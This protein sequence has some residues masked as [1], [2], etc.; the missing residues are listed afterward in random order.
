[1][2]VNGLFPLND[3][4]NILVH[5]VFRC[6]KPKLTNTKLAWNLLMSSLK[7]TYARASTVDPLVVG[8]FLPRKC[9]CHLSSYSSK[10]RSRSSGIN[11]N[12]LLSLKM[13]KPL[14]IC[15]G[16]TFSLIAPWIPR[17]LDIFSLFQTSI[18]CFA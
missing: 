5:F 15:L 14:D 1:M 10:V 6:P 17:D 18:L 16:S 7:I 9:S 11:Q 3:K 12:M 4:S 8:A 2:H 13:V